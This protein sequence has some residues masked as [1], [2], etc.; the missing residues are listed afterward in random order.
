MS[1]LSFP[2]VMRA[3]LVLVL[4]GLL[5]AVLQMVLFGGPPERSPLRPI[6]PVI[7]AAG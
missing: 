6:L 2:H 1:G 7:S 5:F 3:A 4:G